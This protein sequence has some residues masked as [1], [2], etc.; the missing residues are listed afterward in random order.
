[1]TEISIIIPVYNVEKYLDVCLNSVIMQ[2]FK[3]FEVICVNDGA[4]DN[5]GKIL[6]KYALFDKRIKIITQNNKGLSAARNRGVQESKGK[7]LTFIDSDD[8]VSPI[9]LEKLYQNI[10]K[11]QSDYVFC[12]LT[13]VNAKTNQQYT[14]DFLNK[15]KFFT[16]VKK[17]YF[18]EQDV[19]AD[20]YFQIHTTA[21]AKLFRY[22]FIKNFRF[23]E[24]LIFEDSP[25]HARCFL[26]A[27]RIS[28]DFNPYYFYRTQRVGSIIASGDNRLK[29]IFKI[30]DMQESIFKEFNKFDKYKH[31]LLTVYMRDVI[32]KMAGANHDTKKEM[33]E[34]LKQKYSNIDYSQYDRQII[35]N[36]KMVQ[37]YQKI[38]QMNFAEFEK[39]ID[40]LLKRNKNG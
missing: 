2:T 27:K 37:F 17:N 23:P 19:S 13:C 21:Y 9:M 20:I 22:D 16:Q 4:T 5:S 28:F 1:M 29:D 8:W 30:I 36:E 38:L 11:N 18:C 6:E 33:F 12:N 31:Y 32:D 35:Q 26:S 24:G 25:Y 3:D 14:W 39:F 15:E 40:N 10:K 34:L 7:F